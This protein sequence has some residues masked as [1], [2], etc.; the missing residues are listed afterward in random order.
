VTSRDVRAE[1]AD[2]ASGDALLDAVEQIALGRPALV[3]DLFSLPRIG[4]LHVAQIEQTANAFR[5]G[6]TSSEAAC[7][8][9]RSWGS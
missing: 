1:E 4:A 8:A 2:I 9:R 5:G 3:P 6:I 7:G